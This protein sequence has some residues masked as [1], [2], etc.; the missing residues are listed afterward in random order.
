[1]HSDSVGSLDGVCH[2]KHA[3]PPVW[4]ELLGSFG[5]SCRGEA[6]A[7]C[8]N[9]RTAALLGQLGLASERG[10]PRSQLLS[11]VWPDRDSGLAA[12]AF[13]TVVHTLHEQLGEALGGQSPVLEVGGVCGLNREAGIGVDV[14]DF[15]ALAAGAR[16]QART[17]DVR[18]AASLA[19]RASELYR[20][21]LQVEPDGTPHA[22]L[23]RVR[24][25]AT[26][27]SM[28]ALVADDAFARADFSGCLEHALRL[29]EHDACREDAHRLVMRC[30]V[31]QGERTRALQHFEKVREIL[32]LE[33]E[34]ATT[35]L[36]ERM[37][38]HPGPA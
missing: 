2:G 11:L 13:D 17:G 7:V 10:M 4:L 20:G 34:P 25:R 29:L 8:A 3:P 16:R 36:Y 9:T 18:A 5:L 37:R 22:M 19:L 26:W 27:L 32:Q 15:T 14:S 21:D 31:R 6:L 38:L 35:A 30:Y 24:L 12:D 28:L 33:P 1:M 23:E